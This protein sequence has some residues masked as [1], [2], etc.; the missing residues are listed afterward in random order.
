[1]SGTGH[2]FDRLTRPHTRRQAFKAALAGAAMTLPLARPAPAIAA[3]AGPG[4][5][6]KGCQWT[7]HRQADEAFSKCRNNFLY[8][9]PHAVFLA[10]YKFPPAGIAEAVK[11][12]SDKQQCDDRALIAKKLRHYECLQPNC[13]GFDPESKLGP[14]EPCSAVPGCACCASATSFNGYDFCTS[15]PYCCGTSPTGG[16]CVSCGG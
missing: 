8:Q 15:P 13:P 3:N 10:F 16:G 4:A 5:C 7:N 11:L 9:Y 14:C 2:W 12:I 6:R 1:M